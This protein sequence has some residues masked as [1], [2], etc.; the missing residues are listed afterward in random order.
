MNG[1]CKHCGSKL[2]K[3]PY[4]SRHKDFFVLI[5]NNPGCDMY[6]QFQGKEGKQP[7]GV[8]VRLV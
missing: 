5:C 1:K 3:V 8:N 7:E 2:K 4:D 6:R